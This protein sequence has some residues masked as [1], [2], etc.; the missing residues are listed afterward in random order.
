MAAWVRDRGGS[1]ACRVTSTTTRAS[2]AVSRV[3][4]VDH[5]VWIDCEMT[6][7]DASSDRLLEIACLVT[8]AELNILDPGLDLVMSCEE[9]HLAG[10]DE[11]VTTMHATSGLTDLVRSATLSV[12]EAEQQ[13]IDYI[14]GLVPDPKKAPLAGNSIGVDRGF[15]AVWMPRLD[16][17]LHYRMVDVSTVKELARRWYPRAY[18]QSPE[19]AG[20]H[21]ALA[22]IK[23]S[24]QELRY[25]RSAIF[26]P[27]PGPSTEEAQQLA[28]AEVQRTA[29]SDGA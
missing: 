21:R 10:M 13:V 12:E 20:G 3:F 16:A 28:A 15:L 8:D 6:G 14:T 17:S 18:F 5:L 24:V 2:T 27:P 4:T 26:V 19:K 22:D 25:Y 23:E 11:V 1:P 29:Q 7:L 9:E